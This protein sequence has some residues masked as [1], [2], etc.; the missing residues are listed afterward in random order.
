MKLFSFPFKKLISVSTL[1]L[2]ACGAIAQVGQSLWSIATNGGSVTTC[3]VVGPGN[4]AKF[5]IGSYNCVRMVSYPDYHTLWSR[6]V[7]FW[8]GNGTDLP[9]VMFTPDGKDVFVAYSVFSGA[10]KTQTVTEFDANTGSPV[11]FPNSTKIKTITFPADTSSVSLVNNLLVIVES[12]INGGYSWTSYDTTTLETVSGPNAVSLTFGQFVVGTWGS[13]GVFSDGFNNL[14]SLSNGQ[15]LPSLPHSVQVQAF[16]P[17]GGAFCKQGFTYLRY[18]PDS[19]YVPIFKENFQGGPEVLSSGQGAVLFGSTKDHSFILGQTGNPDVMGAFDW[20]TGSFL[21][22]NQAFGSATDYGGYGSSS[23]LGFPSTP[24]FLASVG[25]YQQNSTLY[26]YTVT[27]SGLS[28]TGNSKP[29]VPYGGVYQM[30]A[31]PSGVVIGG[32][33]NRGNLPGSSGNY[34]GLQ[35]A[36][37]GAAIW[38]NQSYPGRAYPRVSPSGKYIVCCYTG[39][40]SSDS[41]VIYDAKTGVVQATLPNGFSDA[42][43]VDDSRLIALGALAHVLTFDATGKK[44]VDTGAYPDIACDYGCAIGWQNITV[45]GQLVQDH[46]AIGFGG[47][48]LVAV[49]LDGYVPGV[50]KLPFSILPGGESIYRIVSLQNGSVACLIPGDSQ[51]PAFNYLYW[52]V[53]TITNGVLQAGSQFKYKT[54]DTYF[55]SLFGFFATGDYA[56]DGKV[57]AFAEG[58]PPDTL[59]GPGASQIQIVRASDGALLPPINGVFTQVGDPYYQSNVGAYNNE[60]IG[61]SWDHSLLYVADS[62]GQRLS[63]VP[64]PNWIS[65]VTVSPSPAISGSSVTLNLTLDRPVPTSLN[66]TGEVITLSVPIGQPAIPNLPATLTIPVGAKTISVTFTVPV[67]SATTTFM[68]QAQTAELLSAG[69]V[70]ASSVKF[71]V[72]PPS[73]SSVAV[74]PNTVI[75]GSGTGVTGTVTLTGRA[76]PGGITVNISSSDTTVA[77]VPVSATVPENATS[78]TFT[79]TPLQVTSVS[80]TT[81]TASFNGTYGTTLLTVSPYQV[82]A[83]SLAPAKVAG[84][85]SSTATVTL[86]QAAGPQGIVV[87]LS[88]DNSDAQVPATVRISPGA[89]TGTFNIT[90]QPVATNE[91]VTISAYI[92]SS[93]QTASLAINSPVLIGISVSPS[94][95]IGGASATG[96]VTIGSPAPSAGTLVQLSSS[97]PVSVPVTVTVPNGQTTATFAVSTTGVDVTGSTPIY[98]KLGSNQFSCQVKVQAANLNTLQVSPNPVLGGSSTIV[99]GKVTLNGLAGPLGVTVNLSSSSPLV[100]LPATVTVPANSSSATFTIATSQVNVATA[101]TITG[102]G[103]GLSQKAILTLNPYTVSGLTISPATIT[104]GNTSTGAVTI[105]QPAGPAGILVT[106]ASSNSQAQVPAT[107]TIPSGQTTATFTINSSPVPSDTTVTITANIGASKTTSS[108]R[109]ILPALTSLTLNTASLVGG[110]PTTGLVTLNGLASPGGIVVTLSSNN[111]SAVVPATITIPGGS[112]TATFPVTTSGVNS[113][114]SATVSAQLATIIKTA[115]LTI[116]PAS[117][118]SVTVSPSSVVGGSPTTVMGTVSLTGQAGPAGVMIKLSSSA[119]SAAT[120]PASITIAAGASIGQFP[121]TTLQVT[122][123][124]KPILTAGLGT[125][126]SSTTITVNPYLVSNILLSPTTVNGGDTCTGTVTLNAPTPP[127]GTVVH[128]TS[129]L[130]TV[131]VPATLAVPGGSNSGSFS[132]TTSPVSSPTSVKIGGW[133][134]TKPSSPVSSTITIVPPTIVGAVFAPASV[135]AGSPTT[136]Y[137]LLSGPAPGGASLKVSSS[138]TRLKVGASLT[139]ASGAVLQSFPLK[140]TVG[141]STTVTVTISYNGSSSTDTLT[142][143]P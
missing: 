132:A 48:N 47:G 43:W 92:G 84:G 134:G 64:V 57:F 142:I 87:N 46:Y 105:S 52:D 36:L 53:F 50:T 129:S 42:V 1:I 143:T 89:T 44:L 25:P 73:I 116:L 113:S 14:W 67:V 140:T 56:S 41:V 97:A 66:A 72:N 34:I 21:F 18:A 106:L 70:P 54:S 40:T 6:P 65:S 59:G 82:T 111:S 5:A 55:N 130:A 23:I 11:L 118:S 120:V 71:T 4:T 15:Q 63:A 125:Y 60:S 38:S 126:S 137:V 16:D 115:T 69:T 91:A 58:P 124:A 76:G 85:T 117:L 96:T 27:D 114:Q 61:F 79:V 131:R 98:A 13:Q 12:Q 81:I 133:V 112:A 119:L 103:G 10:T 68:I 122:T 108:L 26:D 109:L 20:V 127:G 95:V 80:S 77:T 31:T 9:L 7:G 128:L 28:T 83:L 45:N 19:N 30:V 33:N 74:V 8:S 104:G 3:P 121:V 90:T 2:M 62:N 24:H 17:G 93:K 49:E 29:N 101:V 37:D 107:V 32:G 110:N 141:G 86:S 51:D 94:S 35:S 102:A 22:Q 88:S 100:S 123:V 136:L 75:G 139:L 138:S 135:A 99:T 39:T 78:A